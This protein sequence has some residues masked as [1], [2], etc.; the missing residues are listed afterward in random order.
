MARR[1]EILLIPVLLALMVQF[2]L[3][4]A[5]RNSLAGRAR[6]AEHL[7]GLRQ[8]SALYEADNGGSFPPV[9]SKKPGRDRLWH[10]WPEYL[11]DYTENVLFFSCPED[12]NGGQEQLERQDD[13]LPHGF[14]LRYVSFGMNFLLGAN[15]SSNP[16]GRR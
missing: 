7:R 5:E 6:C 10:Y 3:M 16:N 11:R 1:T 14:A 13:L 15:V 12:D 2:L 8:A 9:I 4:A